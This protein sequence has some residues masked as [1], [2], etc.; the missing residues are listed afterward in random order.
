VFDK[1]VSC[2]NGVI[3]RL[4]VDSPEAYF[5]LRIATAFEQGDSHDP[6]ERIQLAKA[7]IKN[8]LLGQNASDDSLQNRV[9][10]Q[11]ASIAATKRGTLR[12]WLVLLVDAPKAR[13]QGARDAVRCFREILGDLET[14]TQQAC[15]QLEDTTDGMGVTNESQIVLRYAMTEL[16][17]VTFDSV[18]QIVRALKAEILVC[19]D[20]LHELSRRILHLGNEFRD[21]QASTSEVDNEL[22]R[23]L[24]EH[25]LELTKQLDRELTSA[26]VRKQM[27]LS[28]LLTANPEVWTNLVTTMRTVA[29]RLASNVIN[30]MQVS[31]MMEAQGN[32]TGDHLATAA[33][34]VRAAESRLLECGG[35]CR[36]LLVA[37][38]S[39]STW[40]DGWRR[41]FDEA[42]SV[43][44]SVVAGIDDT[45][46][47][48]CESQRI[49]LQNVVTH[50][51]GKR[52]DLVKVA[53]RLHTRI[54]VDWPSLERWLNG[55]A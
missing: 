51:V 25:H 38:R 32:R 10:N 49:P 9:R 7:A 11:V 27:S 37:P 15:A 24:K 17:G 1:L 4:L 53:S 19:E 16:Q 47:V 44:T 2:V 13:V 5:K 12:D 40:P 54:D 52:T 45:L 35:S 34:T 36:Y 20:H 26:L 39:A 55:K 41:P 18:L 30:R 29:Q 6:R 14:Q 22:I 28:G 50:L 31:R 42:A 43:S 21:P 48:C 8:E 23:S 33:D 46:V 3:E